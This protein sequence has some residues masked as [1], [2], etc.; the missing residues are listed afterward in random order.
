MQQQQQLA[1]A[2]NIAGQSFDGSVYY[3]CSTDLPNIQ[4]NVK[5]RSTSQKTPLLKL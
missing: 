5:Q 3:Y 2:R 4:H 1:T